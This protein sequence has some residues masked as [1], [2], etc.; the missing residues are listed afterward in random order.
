MSLALP[1]PNV[2]KS[3]ACGCENGVVMELDVADGICE[4][5]QAVRSAMAIPMRNTVL[6]LASYVM[7]FLFYGFCN[8]GCEPLFRRHGH[9]DFSLHTPPHN[10]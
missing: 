1:M 7:D 2:P 4:D 10:N 8:K 5:E 3:I 9:P 6:A